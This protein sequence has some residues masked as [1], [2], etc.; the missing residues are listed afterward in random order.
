MELE[1]RNFDCQEHPPCLVLLSRNKMARQ[2]DQS[3]GSESARLVVIHCPGAVPVSAPLRNRFSA[4]INVTGV[5][6][7]P[8]VESARRCFHFGRNQ[9]R[10]VT[11]GCT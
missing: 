3:D 7:G 2:L 1:R 6:V 8:W 9:A 5:H 4:S 11:P 10:N